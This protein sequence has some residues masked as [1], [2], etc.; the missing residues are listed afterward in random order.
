MQAMN[1]FR[2]NAVLDDVST[3]ELCSIYPH[4]GGMGQFHM[5]DIGN[6]VITETPHD[7]TTVIQLDSA[8]TSAI[9]AIEG[10]I[11]ASCAMCIE[12]GLKKVP[13]VKDASVNL[14]TEQATVSGRFERCPKLKKSLKKSS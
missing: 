4:Q 3:T 12:K 6:A 8:E 2:Q 10:M 7:T 1:A 5:Q 14:A 9:F 13:G 11:C